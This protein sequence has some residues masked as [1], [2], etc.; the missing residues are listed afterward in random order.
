MKKSE[1]AIVLLFALV[2]GCVFGR[3]GSANPKIAFNSL[4][5]IVAWSTLALL[6]LPGKRFFLPIPRLGLI[7]VAL[8]LVFGWFMVINARAYYLFGEIR[9]ELISDRLWEE[10]PGSVTKEAS[11]TKMFEVSGLFLCLFAAVR[12]RE[13]KSW[14]GLL[15]IIP[16]LGAMITL[17]GLYHRVLEAPAVWFVDQK[18]PP[19]FFAPFIYNAHAGSYLNFSGAIGFAFWIS[20]LQR[21]SSS[22]SIGWG[23][24]TALCFLGAIATASKGA[25]LILLITLAL[26]VLMHR[27]RLWEFCSSAKGRLGGQGFE[28]KLLIL[29]SVVLV[30]CFALVGGQKL[31]TRMNH[32]VE[33]AKDGSAGTVEGRKGIMRVM[34]KMGS[35]DEGGWVGFGPGSFESVVPF[36][37]ADEDYYIPGRWLH[38]HSDPLQLV[39][40]WGYIGA[41]LWVALALGAVYH[42]FRSLGEKGDFS[43]RP[44]TRGMIIALVSMTLH[45]CFDFPFGIFSLKLAAIF[46]CGLLWGGR[47]S[48][49]S[50]PGA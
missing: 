14:T 34:L 18:H 36:F 13:S 15:A 49:R 6:I 32:F 1:I 38:G 44:L 23:I 43:S 28:R 45:S 3:Y 25:F 21:A 41:A 12:S 4:C 24:V 39:V 50:S 19:T 27:K 29:A 35:E 16:I 8:I 46:V 22:K 37:L 9:F 47:S 20:S 30:A 40:E 11:V 2:M 5:L 48:R 31:V 17:I 7:I 10:G 42:G 33:D 26:C